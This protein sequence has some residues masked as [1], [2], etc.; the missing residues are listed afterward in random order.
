MPDDDDATDATTGDANPASNGDG[1]EQ[2]EAVAEIVG[3]TAAHENDTVEPIQI[4]EEMERSFLD[5]AMS[6]I[7]SRALPD[8]RDGLKPVHRRILYGM[9]EGGLRP[10]RPHKKCAAAVG[11]VMGKYHPHGDS[12][13]YDALAR[14]AQD[15]SL[16]HPLIDGHGNFGSP[17]PNDR[18]AAMRYCVVAGTRVRTAEGTPRIDALAGETPNSDVSIDRKVV[19]ERGQL[20]STDRAFHSG[21]HPTL[22][23]RTREGFEITGTA[24]HPVLC[25]EPV[26]GVPMLQWKLLEEIG[27]G[28]IVVIDRHYRDADATAS[29]RQ[30]SAAFLAGAFVSEGWVSEGRAGFNNVDKAFFGAVLAAYDEAVG[31][32]RYVY[33]RVI[34]SGSLLHELD[35]QDLSSLRRSVLSDSIG[36]R[37]AAKRI[38]EFVWTGPLDAK[39]AFL[40]SLFE[41]DGCVSMLPRNTVQ[42]SYST[43]SA[44]LAHDVQL[45][46]LEFGVIGRL[47]FAKNGEIKVV[48]TNRRDARLFQQRV[49]FWGVKQGKLDEIMSKIPR[50]SRALSHD[51]VPF[52]AA[53][54]RAEEPSGWLK[55]YN[56]D[57]VE[58]WERDHDS[59][60]AHIAKAEVRG[61]IEPLVHGGYYYAPVA[62]V[63]R[64]DDQ[65]VYSIRVE[66]EGHA[67]SAGGFV[68]HN[69][70][71]RLAPL[72]MRLLGEIDED[73]VD[74][75][76]TY[77]GANQQP[78]VLPARF[79]NLLVNGVGGIAVG[80]ATNIPPHNLREVIDATIHLLEHPEADSRDLMEFVHGPDFPTGAQILGR[81]GINELYLTGRGSV[82]MRAVAEIEEHRGGMRI[83]V[84]EIPYQTSPEVIGQKIAELV[85]E[86]RIEGVR[87]VRNATAGN[88]ISLVVDLKRDA[89]AQVVLN[90]LYKHT[91]MQTSFAANVLALVD[92]IPRL[93]G[94]REALRVYIDHQVDVVTRRSEH[95]LAKDRRRAHIVEGLLRALDMIDAIIQLI[96]GSED[97]SAARDGLMAEPLSFS[98]EQAQHILDMQLRRLAQ[99]EGQRLKDEFDELQARITDLEAILGDDAKLRAVIKEE[100]IDTRDTFGSDRRTQLVAD[101]GEIA[102]LDLIDDEELVVMLSQ[103]G[104]VKSVQPDQFRSQGR[105]GRGI[106]GAKLR[107]E[108]FVEH[109]LM[110]TA[111]SYLLFFSNRGRVYRL[112]AHEIPMME[113]TAR[114]SALV[115]LL[116][117]QPDEHIEAII[118]TRTYEDGA[119]LLFATRKGIVKKTRMSE[120]DS[121]L[122]AGLIA[123]N[124]NEDD[125]LVRVVQTNG[126]DD[127]LL[128]SRDGM[129]IRFH[130]SDVR[131]M[132]R[133]AAGVRGMRLKHGRDGVVSCD[134]ARDDA[135]ML[136]VSSSGHGKR[137]RCDAFHTQGRGGQGV[138]G[139]KV[140]QNRGEVVSAMT[141]DEDDEVLVFS[142]SGNIIRTAVAEISIQGRAG[143]GVRVARVADGESVVAVARVLE[144]SDTADDDDRG[145][146]EPD[147]QEG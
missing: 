114:G 103:G 110:T 109:L 3:E 46:L 94:L 26:A 88:T 69:T 21:T 19:G 59:I 76:P 83:V 33:E 79:P 65:P 141:V 147:T 66:S 145:E 18:P 87:D 52:L 115:N 24:N 116:A 55:K 17:D 119:Y 111:H 39:R 13:I 96:R 140:T 86:R 42:I 113:R 2:P 102:T 82:K 25:L 58:R 57:R 47:S 50:T 20:V 11:D 131:S 64:A 28:A 90:Q 54:V 7:T 41:G 75:E 105:G 73:T 95:R 34:A 126:D 29:D 51:H 36:L 91:P 45:M 92:G 31:G 8:A 97:A 124:L 137:T 122:R 80:M 81:T 132:G 1:P 128:V 127:I 6:V 16:R 15:F 78:V 84:S 43:R 68:N 85:N 4:Q 98:E 9:Y 10:D 44:Q 106:T 101:P 38:P 63:T 130:E 60:L 35:V 27:P 146:M 5:Y 74:M 143:T 123:I 37:S 22:R 40:Q 30:V 112:R 108:D 89:N 104:Y 136:F 142:S 53:Y 118:D 14:M 23:L 56:I 100:L 12:A 138:R 67:F 107:D 61:V 70:E 99:L 134:V 135:V 129:T 62:S 93:L 71:A 121:S 117:L 144:A 125:E 77:D 72:A 48:I 120:Y 139:M 49:G 133:A 32:R